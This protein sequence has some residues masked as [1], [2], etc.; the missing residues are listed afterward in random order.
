[1]PP[2][3]RSSVSN[4][5]NT[6]N[7]SAST[8]DDP[9]E[10]VSPP[11]SIDDSTVLATVLDSIKAAQ[12]AIDAITLRLTNHSNAIDATTKN[13]VTLEHE[14]KSIHHSLVEL[15][16][17]V[18]TKLTDFQQNVE[19]KVETIQDDLRHEFSTN[20][21]TLGNQ[22][23][24][25]ISSNQ[26][27][28]NT[29]FKNHI[30]TITTL[31]DTVRAI[32]KNLTALQENNLS[33]SEIE[34]L[35]V[36]KWEDELDPHIKSHYDFKQAASH[37]L[38]ALDQTLQDSVYSILQNTSS[39][40][41]TTTR[42]TNRSTGFYQQSSKDFS[43]S[44]L[45][46][47]LKEIKLC[48]DT[49][50]D[51]EIFWDAVLG[52]FTNLCQVNQAYPYY[53][54]L[55]P[56]FTFKKHLVDPIKP[57]RYL[58]IEC[59]QV[60]RNYRSFG[61]ALRIFLQSGTT[62]VEGTSPKTYLQLLSLCDTRD[63][64]L[65][66]NT[67]IFSLSP[68]LSGDYHDYR[69]DIDTLSI[70]PG[71]HL[72]KFYQR[73]IQLSNEIILS[74]IQNG[75]L[76]LLAYRFISLLRSTK[77]TTIIGLINPYWKTITKHRRD[78]N[79]LIAPLPW[80]FKEVY[81]D[82]IC[83]DILYLPNI[84]SPN[85]EHTVLP[86]AARGTS[87]ISTTTSKSITPSN[88]SNAKST[89]IGIHRTKD[90]RR[91]VSHNNKLL[92]SK[93]PLCQLCSNKHANPWHATE[94]CPYKHPTHIL[95]KDIREKVMQHNALH[96]AENKNYHKNQDIP[97][98]TNTPRQATGHSATTLESSHLPFNDSTPTT[99]TEELDTI[100]T[101]SNSDSSDSPEDVN[102]IIETEYFD[103]PLVSATANAAS[104]TIDTPY[105]DIESDAVITDHLQYLSYES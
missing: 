49:L 86:F 67:L 19:L 68:Q 72:S 39:L 21:I 12:R 77:C 44:K 26:D 70:I 1:M 41:N 105:A 85:L 45:Q 103:I 14:F 3:T 48:G 71:E 20:L 36:Q 46:K 24:S 66:L 52:A 23:N 53:R 43:V 80:N 15:P 40:A 18:D 97:T 95:S 31:S 55:K 35:I 28:T 90:G 88:V 96:G 92:S 102:E 10:H 87:N 65:L 6:S 81:D 51:L 13:I 84:P 74:N 61:D 104:T 98:S 27:D 30:T 17:I 76:A 22:L 101:M 83:S 64:F 63:G 29:C 94:D 47:E 59:D 60:Q 99:I 8:I 75:N 69:Q 73:V 16:K 4:D 89:T 5:S 50:K 57:P 62:I 7:R 37:R 25:V 78:P 82:L 11:D 100:P 42:T 34:R 38:D 32:N 9:V 2:K 91:F 56:D 58:P 54:D 79:H 33:K 93:Q